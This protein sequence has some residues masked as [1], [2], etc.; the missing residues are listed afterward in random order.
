MK[1]L[2]I[3]RNYLCYCGIEKDEYRSLKKSAYISNFEV[4]RVLHCLM[5]AVFAGL[6]VLSLSVDIMLDNQEFYISALIYSVI[7]SWLFLFVLKKDSIAAQLVIYLSISMLFLFACFI[8]QNKPDLP[9][10]TFIVFLLITPM[11]MIDKPY[12]MGIELSAASAIYL[13]WMRSVKP[14]EIWKMDC[15]N[16]VVFTVIGFFLHVIANSIRIK[17]FVLTKKIN[18][19]KDT[20]DLTGLKN[21]GAITREINRFLTDASKDKGIMFLL[22]IDHFKSINDTYGHDVGDSVISQFGAFLSKTFTGGEIAGRFGGDEFIVFIKDSDDPVLAEKT[23]RTI[24]DGTADSVVLP[25]ADK[26]VSVSIGIAIYHGSEKNYSEIFKKAD[27]ALYNT[28]SDRTVN[29]VFFDD[30]LPEKE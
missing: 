23:A 1:L 14:L 8:T 10:T 15:G 4:W 5:T 25:D 9:A 30:S 27:L 3:V 13:V 18:V 19:Q 20:D 7:V 29:Y 12:F 21:K 6:F 28:K 11:F 26:K 24:V 16:V 22:D 2:R 17:E